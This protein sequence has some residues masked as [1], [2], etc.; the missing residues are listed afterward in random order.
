MVSLLLWPFYNGPNSSRLKGTPVRMLWLPNNF[1]NI[2]N[3]RKQATVKSGP[4]WVREMFILAKLPLLVNRMV[5]K[6][7]DWQLLTRLTSEQSTLRKT[8][9]S[10]KKTPAVKSNP[11]EVMVNMLWEEGNVSVREVQPVL[12]SLNWLSSFDSKVDLCICLEDVIIHFVSK[13]NSITL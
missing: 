3:L 10:F 13:V 11:Q 8:Q 2:F 12:I 6:F 5:T 9:T 1:S 7:Q 4:I